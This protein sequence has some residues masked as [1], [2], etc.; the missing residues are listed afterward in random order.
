[1]NT[2]SKAKLK[3]FFEAN[4]FSVHL[5]TQDNQECAEVEKW[6][7]GGVDMIMYLQPF[8]V[9]SFLNFVEEFSVDEQIDLHRQG[10]SYTDRFTISQSLKDFTD[11]HNHLKEVAAELTK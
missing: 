10:K 2:K 4:D 6:T 5:F 9:K 1:M 8:T 3:A 11:F 7:E